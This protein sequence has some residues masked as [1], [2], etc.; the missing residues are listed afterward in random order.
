MS[1]LPK[2]CENMNVRWYFEVLKRE[3]NANN[4]NTRKT[5]TRTAHS[6]QLSPLPCPLDRT[7]PD[8]NAVASRASD[9]ADMVC[10]RYSPRRAH[11][12]K[13]EDPATLFNHLFAPRLR[14]KIRAYPHTASSAQN[15]QGLEVEV[16]LVKRSG[17]DSFTRIRLEPVALLCAVDGE[18][19]IRAC[20]C[21]TKE[22]KL[23]QEPCP[24]AALSIP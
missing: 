1:L 24:A 11:T 2:S 6:S 3:S 13:P 4:A 22:D 7:Q 21:K 19:D 9:P 16:A 18:P 15:A 17:A 8:T 10:R 14:P 5:S 12:A 20:Q 23:H